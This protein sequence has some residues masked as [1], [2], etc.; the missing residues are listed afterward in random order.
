MAEQLPYAAG[1][2][3]S[4]L[5]DK[6]LGLVEKELEDGKVIKIDGCKDI[7]WEDFLK[8]HPSLRSN[9]DH[10]IAAVLVGDGGSQ[11]GRLPELLNAASKQNL[12]LLIIVIDNGRAIN[13]F[14]PDVATNTMKYTL[15]DHYKVP[16]ILVDGLNAVD[17]AKAGR[18]VTDY[19]RS[20]KG[21]AVMQIHTYRFLGHSPA[22][23]E[24]EKGRKEE[25]MWARDNYD[26]IQAFEDKYTMDGKLTHEELASVKKEVKSIVDQAVKFAD[27]SPMPP[28]NLAKELEF[29]TLVGTDYNQ[30]APPS[31]ADAVNKRSISPERMEIINAHISELRAKAKSGEITIADAANLALH[32]EMLRDPT[33]T[34][35][36][37]TSSHKC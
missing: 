31:F 35:K 4:I 36:C 17:V 33:T 16:G 29:P 26:P 20:G 1:A 12:P 5:I 37:T 24:H 10:R 3:K 27:E 8:T 6:E 9:D 21:P 14:T 28:E 13:T 7:E 32:E 11:N 22:D 19:I 25:K 18:A 15:G 30:L 23:P 34:S 2:A